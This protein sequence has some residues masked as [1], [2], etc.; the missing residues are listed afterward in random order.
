MFIH[1]KFRFCINFG[2]EVMTQLSSFSQ[3]VECSGE[4]NTVNQC[5]NLDARSSYCVSISA[6]TGLR[7][8]IRHV[9]NTLCCDERSLLLTSPLLYDRN[10]DRIIGHVTRTR[11]ER[12]TSLILL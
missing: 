3:I 11:S 5:Y 2:N 10:L 7:S 4:L 12:N 8:Q 6:S 9:T 1:G